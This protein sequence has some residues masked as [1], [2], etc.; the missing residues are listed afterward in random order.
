MYACA[1]GVTEVSIWYQN[2]IWFGIAKFH[3]NLA[4]HFAVIKKISGREFGQCRKESESVE[5]IVNGLKPLTVFV[6][7]SI[8]D[9]SQRPVNTFENN[10][11]IYQYNENHHRHFTIFVTQSKKELGTL[12]CHNLRVLF[13][14]IKYF[15]PRKVIFYY[16]RNMEIILIARDSIFSLGFNS[17]DCLCFEELQTPPSNIL[18]IRHQFIFCFMHFLMLTIVHI[19]KCW[20][21]HL[22]E[23]N[24]I[25]FVRCLVNRESF[26]GI[27]NNWSRTLNNRLCTD[28]YC[29]PIK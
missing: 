5:K 14:L 26:M 4:K 22:K 6:E 19:E 29:P 28:W 1:K 2:E 3:E 13:S 20:S 27:P 17:F 9:I 12:F 24:I 25:A 18:V 21:R 8:L 11:K 10:Y 23:F 7:R 16:C 15:P